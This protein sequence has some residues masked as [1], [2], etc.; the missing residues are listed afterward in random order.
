MNAFRKLSLAL[1]FALA[2]FAHP[3]IADTVGDQ[4]YIKGTE[5]AT[6]AQNAY[7]GCLV[8]GNGATAWVGAWTLANGMETGTATVLGNRSS[9]TYG[10]VAIG[11]TTSS[12]YGGTAIGNFSQATT[13]AVAIGFNANAS[14]LSSIAIGSGAVANGSVFGSAIAIGGQATGARTI[15][16]GGEASSQ[17]AVS[18]GHGS[19][20]GGANTVSV[21]D[22]SLRRRIVNVAAGQAANDAVIVS[23]IA[24]LAASLGGGASFTN[25]AFTAPS[26][27]LSTGTYT[28]VGAALTALDNKPSS[29]SASPYFKATSPVSDG[30]DTTQATGQSVVAAG[31]G[32]K[33]TGT[34]N[35]VI[36]A[37]S[38]ASAYGATVIGSLSSAGDSA[39]AGGHQTVAGDASVA[40]GAYAKAGQD[41][42]AI[43]YSAS[44]TESMTASFGSAAGQP[45]RL[46]NIASGQGENDAVNMG[47][48]NSVA[49]QVTNTQSALSSTTSYL[50]GGANYNAVT[51]TITAPSFNFLSGASYNT[52]GDALAD[53]DGRVTGLENAPGGGGSN[54]PGPQGPQGQKGDTGAQGP[55]GE[56]GE[57]GQ[58]G[59][60]GSAKVA[61]GKNI[62]VQTQADGSTSVSLS[63]QIE[64]SDQG[65]IKVAKTIINGDGINAGGNRVTGV[66]NGSIS[67]GSTDAVNGGQ[68]YDMQQQ[69]SDRWEDTTRRVGNLEREVKIQGAQSAAF[70]SMMGAQTSGVIG[71]VHATA[72]VGFYGNK[73]AV[74]VGW[75]ARVSEKVNLSAGFS[76]GMGGGSMQGGIGISVNLGR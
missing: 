25:G 51:N 48:L 9:N 16:I 43:G 73:A 31:P 7:A 32:A 4:I 2:A 21:G 30:S 70:A 72:G 65:S 14:T 20:D 66:G 63:D 76:K 45:V 40:L 59:K 38:G 10:G 8:L 74:A 62:E 53:L 57:S 27:A 68:L 34:Y 22:S 58:D 39:F 71:E 56:K 67:Q 44:C 13:T 3:A 33:A 69:W 29:G 49:V 17:N 75:K 50:G 28:T 5:A 26:Y 61:A 47:Q 52:V 1:S 41:C 6:C 11:D 60:D 36:G 55:K 54:T 35:T 15:A 19:T 42:I 12:S 18:L 23:Q 64:L 37:D 24:P 46:T